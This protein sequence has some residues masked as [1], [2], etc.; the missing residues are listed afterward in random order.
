MIQYHL[1]AI[2]D[3]LVSQDMVLGLFLGGAGLVFLLMGIRMAKS[4]IALSFGV[5]GFVLGGS[6]QLPP[7]LQLLAGGVAAAGLAATDVYAF[8]PAV[9]VL[10]GTWGGL[11]TGGLLNL[12]GTGN[13]VSLIAAAFVFVAVVSL[14]FIMLQEVIA[15]VTSLEGTVLFLAGLVV[16]MSKSAIKLAV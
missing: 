10:A 14:T 1:P 2:L 9:A 5:S 11:M 8:R 13:Q 15:F 3:D 12:L 4:L 6:L 16:F 7:S